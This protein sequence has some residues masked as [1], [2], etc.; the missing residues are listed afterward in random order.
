LAVQASE[1]AQDTEAYDQKAKKDICGDHQ[2]VTE[3]SP[4]FF[5]TPSIP[6]TSG[7]QP[8]HHNDKKADAYCRGAGLQIRPGTK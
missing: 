5:D 6:K 4:H 3:Q 2:P 1:R 8:R 7:P